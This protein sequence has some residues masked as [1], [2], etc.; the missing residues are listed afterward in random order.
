[1]EFH[2]IN[3]SEFVEDYANYQKLG[4]E[5]V[6]VSYD[7]VESHKEF[8]DIYEMEFHL[9]ADTEKELSKKLDVDRFLPWPHPSRQTFLVDPNG[10]IIK[11]YEDVEPSIHSKEILEDFT[12]LQSQQSSE[13]KK[14]ALSIVKKFGS[15]LKPKL[16]GAL[17]SGGLTH[18]IEVCS[19]QAPQI[20]KQLS[21]ESGWSVK[22]VSLKP[23]NTLAAT[24]DIWESKLLT[25]FDQRQSQGEP[26][27]S[28]AKAQLF[29]DHFRFIKAQPVE[30]VCLNCHGTQLDPKVVTA[31][32]K[33][34]KDDKATGY[35]LGQIRGAFSLKKNLN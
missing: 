6:G 22:R 25:E 12:K 4:I 34:Y 29:N 11:H 14:E 27:A 21:S 24:A 19:T 8:A 32:N 35:T 31:L 15:I 16:V 7:D 9:L 26:I 3:I 33:H 13:L 28:L 5:I 2:F 23:R 1:M 10:I 17:K 20:A 30:A 18:A